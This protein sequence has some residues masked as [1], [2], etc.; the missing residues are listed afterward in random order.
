MGQHGREMLHAVR[1]EIEARLAA[2]G[3]KVWGIVN[4]DHFELAPEVEDAYAAMVK[5]LVETS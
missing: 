1:A 5:H 3:H 2:I 4:D